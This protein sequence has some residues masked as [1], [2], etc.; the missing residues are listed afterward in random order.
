MNEV[1][2]VDWFGAPVKRQQSQNLGRNFIHCRQRQNR[3]LVPFTP[4]L[5]T[6][7]KQSNLAL[8][9]APVIAVMSTVMRS[10]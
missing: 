5:E 1:T 7:H 8:V 4:P 2:R 10:S 9:A 3:M 6:P